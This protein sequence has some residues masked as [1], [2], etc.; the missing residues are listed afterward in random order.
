MTCASGFVV[1]GRVLRVFLFTGTKHYDVF[2]KEDA[3]L[4]ASSI[5]TVKKVSKFVREV[6]S[7]SNIVIEQFMPVIC[8]VELNWF[9]S[10]TIL[11]GG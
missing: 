10:S 5:I 6:S 3:I 1:L 2:R 11:G 4:S 7:K 9:K 8:H